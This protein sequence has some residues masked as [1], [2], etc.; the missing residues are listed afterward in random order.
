MGAF[1]TDIQNSTNNQNVYDMIGYSALTGS[2]G[3]ASIYQKMV[4]TNEI[5]PQTRER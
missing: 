1:Y 3:A 5:A 2:N 4:D